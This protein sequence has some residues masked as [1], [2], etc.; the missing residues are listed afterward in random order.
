M[1]AIDDHVR[2]LIELGVKGLI[3]EH[4]QRLGYWILPA[5]VADGPEEDGPYPRLEYQMSDG[6]DGE[7]S[8]SSDFATHA[9]ALAALKAIV[10]ERKR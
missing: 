9:E 3:L 2:A 4:D 10:F 7:R 5:L 6:L 1:S 8:Y